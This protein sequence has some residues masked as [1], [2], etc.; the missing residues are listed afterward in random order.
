MKT[1]FNKEKEKW[2]HPWN[3][4][5]FDNLYNRDERFFSIVI[6]GLI[7]YLNRNIVLYDE[8][9]NH[10]I[11]NTGSSYLYVE[12]NG[13][14]YSMEETSGEDTMYMK[15]PRCI[16]ELSDI[17]IPTEELTSPFSRGYYERQNG[18]AIMGYNAEIRRLPIELTVNAK[19]YLSNFN[20]SIVL[21]QELIDKMIFQNYFNIT[22]LGNIIQCSIEF[23]GSMTP[24]LNKIDMTSPEPN[25][26]N[27]TLDFKI[28]T[29]YPI[30]NERTEIG[31][32]KVIEVFKVNVDPDYHESDDVNNDG[33]NPSYDDPNI[34]YNDNNICGVDFNNTINLDHINEYSNNGCVISE[35]I[36]Y[37]S[38]ITKDH[39]INLLE[40]IKYKQYDSDYDE[41]NDGIIN[42]KDLE[43]IIIK[44]NRIENVSVDYDKFTNK[45]Y[46]D[47][48]DTGEHEEIDLSKYTIN[49]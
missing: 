17:S 42:V 14:E 46:I 5:Q 33:Y 28:C 18:N 49:N 7:S 25:Q 43:E 27:I 12:S 26:R 47:H 8:S 31:T 2:I 1:V 37:D 40:K 23:P 11:F 13:Y 48:N 24:Q 16:L 30:I 39:I 9:I 22:Y 44:S 32:D 45:L 35:M 19:Y 34:I 38:S 29:S 36:P 10:F 21:L 41:N 6:K 3:I 4:K 20:E 15:L